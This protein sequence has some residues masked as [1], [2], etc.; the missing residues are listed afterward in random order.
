MSGE[1]VADRTGNAEIRLE[2]PKRDR[3]ALVA[4]HAPAVLAEIRGKLAELREL[5]LA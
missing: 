4:L 3:R 2:P 5:T 1:S